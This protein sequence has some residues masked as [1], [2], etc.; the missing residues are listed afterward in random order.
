M[1]MLVPTS[2]GREAARDKNLVEP[3]TFVLP[4][5][6]ATNKR[7]ALKAAFRRLGGCLF[8]LFSLDG[9]GGVGEETGTLKTSLE[10]SIISQH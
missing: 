4:V 5:F 6:T 10:V 7:D 2:R 3:S 8:V 1:W 9:R